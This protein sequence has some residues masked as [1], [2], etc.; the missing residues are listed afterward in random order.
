MKEIEA[1][2]LGQ[3]KSHEKRAEECASQLR[4]AEQ[5]L[6]QAHREVTMYKKKVAELENALSASAMVRPI[7]QN[8]AYLP[9]QQR[10]RPPSTGPP[11]GPPGPHPQGTNIMPAR[12]I[13]APRLDPRR[14]SSPHSVDGSSVA[15]GG[16][17]PMMNTS[18][19]PPA[20]HVVGYRAS[21]P[22]VARPMMNTSLPP[23][24]PNTRASLPPRPHSRGAGGGNYDA[25]RD[26]MNASAD[27]ML[28]SGGGPPPGSRP[29]PPGPGQ[30]PLQTPPP[31][32]RAPPPGFM[33]GDPMR[34][35]PPNLYR[36]GGPYPPGPTYPGPRYPPRMDIPPPRAAF[37]GPRPLRP[38][39]GQ[40]VPPHPTGSHSGAQV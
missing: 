11:P 33:G 5:E 13:S 38:P 19:P 29:R 2:Y 6:R 20:S 17:M 26:R 40:D 21:L 4:H 32:P 39:S 35:P 36:G 14:S 34:R 24:G 8:S 3:A 7:P 31:R 15:V 16:A 12:P 30:R 23:P 22:Q 37:N 25:Q 1:S 18:L 28:R 9:P 27:E 10:S